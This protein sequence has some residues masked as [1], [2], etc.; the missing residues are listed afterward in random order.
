M[1]K[2]VFMV[3]LDS[4]PYL[5]VFLVGLENDSLVKHPTSQDPFRTFGNDTLPR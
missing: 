2:K 5:H 3:K 1:R 4:I